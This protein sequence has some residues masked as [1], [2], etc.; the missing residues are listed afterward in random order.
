MRSPTTR[1]LEFFLPSFSQVSSFSRPSIRTLEPLFKYS[2][3]TSA[4]RP[5]SVTSTNVVS[6]THS[7][8][9]VLAAVVDCQPDVGHGRSAGDV[10]QLGI[11]RQIAD[12]DH[13]IVTGHRQLLSSRTPC[14]AMVALTWPLRLRRRSRSP[15]RRARRPEPA[16]P[17]LWR[18]RRPWSPLPAGR[19]RAAAG[20]SDKGM[21]H[22][23]VG[24]PRIDLQKQRPQDAIAQLAL[25]RQFRQLVAVE[26]EVGQPVGA[27]AMAVDG[28]G[29]AAFLPQAAGEHFAAQL[30]D[31]LGNLA[32]YAC[33]IAGNSGW[34]PE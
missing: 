30:S 11:A 33:L 13:A 16:R 29:Q 12:Q 22:Q 31:H 4:C 3:A 7:P 32:R 27:L 34:S 21:A 6:S 20:A 17:L 18:A 10:P 1:S 28:I 19:G 5:Q 14:R 23:G 25:P 9:A 26:L 15:W 2:L 8:L 24:D